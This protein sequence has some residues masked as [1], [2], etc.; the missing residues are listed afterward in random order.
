MPSTIG[1]TLVEQLYDTSDGAYDEAMTEVI[2]QYLDPHYAATALKAVVK[3][4]M[5]K[6][7]HVECHTP[8]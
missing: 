6:N 8:A 1:E 7:Y 5:L 2:K 3:T 4:S